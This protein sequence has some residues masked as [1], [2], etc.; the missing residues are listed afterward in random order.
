[1]KQYTEATFN[2]RLDIFP[3]ERTFLDQ[4]PNQSLYY[5][6]GRVIVR[7]DSGDLL[8]SKL[9]ED[10]KEQFMF[11][12]QLEAEYLRPITELP[13]EFREKIHT[14]NELNRE[15]SSKGICAVALESEEVPSALTGKKEELQFALITSVSHSENTYFRISIPELH[16]LRAEQLAELP[17][18]NEE[19]TLADP[20]RV[21]LEGDLLLAY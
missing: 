18:Y 10:N 12:E 14:L 11:G 3:A 16:A 7:S 8:F 4:E 13:D 21:Q 20:Y 1:M 5:I 17:E 15:L 2:E 19:R 9:P 6:D